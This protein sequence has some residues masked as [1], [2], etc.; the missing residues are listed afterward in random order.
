ES[1]LVTIWP[2]WDAGL[3]GLPAVAAKRATRPTSESGYQ[4]AWTIAT[5]MPAAKATTPAVQ[6][7]MYLRMFFPC[8]EIGSWIGPMQLE[9]SGFGMGKGRARSGPLP[10]AAGN[11]AGNSQFCQSNM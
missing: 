8:S 4:P 3:T 5:Y 6:N 9:R 7:H 11:V 1:G 10:D 2:A